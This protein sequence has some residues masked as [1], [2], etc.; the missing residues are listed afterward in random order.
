MEKAQDQG[1]MVKFGLMSATLNA[2]KFSEHFGGA[3]IVELRADHPV[4]SHYAA[5]SISLYR[6]PGK[7]AELALSIH[8]SSSWGYSNFYAWQQE[9]KATIDEMLSR[10]ITGATIL[11]LY[12][13]LSPQERQGFL[14]NN[15]EEK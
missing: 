4:E 8:Q 13:E 1:S 2:Q 10:N 12:S 9:I 7:S 3:P 5:D 15:Q 14:K 6:M 11:P